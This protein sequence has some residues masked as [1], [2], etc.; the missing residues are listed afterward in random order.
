ESIIDD[1]FD[2]SLVATVAEG[3]QGKGLT[4][5]KVRKLI[6]GGPYSAKA[7]AQLG[8]IDRVAYADDYKASL[9]AALKADDVKLVKDYEKAKSKDVNLSNPFELLKLLSP[10]KAKESKNAKVAV[11]YATGV[12]TTG[13]SGVSLMGGESCG[14]TTMIE[15]I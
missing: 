4:A 3:R 6:D 5:E 13:K 8:L 9:K 2:K 7:A 12:I 14:S 1:Y 15:A 11:I 10:T